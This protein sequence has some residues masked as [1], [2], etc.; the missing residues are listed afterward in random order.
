MS[1]PSIKDSQADKY[2]DDCI[3][4]VEYLDNFNNSIEEFIEEFGMHYG[5][6]LSLIK[7]A[8]RML[9]LDSFPNSQFIDI[10]EKLSEIAD[11]V[12]KKYNK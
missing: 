11:E 12:A 3:G 1:Q 5:L 10:S 7:T 8:E 6:V 4:A 9:F 2:N